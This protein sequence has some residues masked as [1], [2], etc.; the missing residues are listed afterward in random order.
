MALISMLRLTCKRSIC[1]IDREG[2][3]VAKLMVTVASAAI[4]LAVFCLGSF[5]GLVALLPFGIT[6]LISRLGSSRSEQR[7]ALWVG[8]AGTLL[9]PFLAA[10]WINHQT[11]GYF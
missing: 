6:A 1:P 4:L 10:I 9:L 11:W 8:A 7:R 3:Y 2:L 5:V